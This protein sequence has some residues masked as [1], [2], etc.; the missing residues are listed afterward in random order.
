VLKNVCHFNSLYF[1][2]FHGINKKKYGKRI[3]KDCKLSYWSDSEYRK[4]DSSLIVY[5][6]FGDS[7]LKI[8]MNTLQFIL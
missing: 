1:P 2:T 4:M 7:R 5:I 8:A 6:L 3:E